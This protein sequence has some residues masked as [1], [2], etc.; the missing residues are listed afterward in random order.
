MN[1]VTLLTTSQ[2]TTQTPKNKN[3]KRY[4]IAPNWKDA[5]TEKTC[6]SWLSILHN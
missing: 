2:K 5:H 4:V 6:I 1:I 3:K